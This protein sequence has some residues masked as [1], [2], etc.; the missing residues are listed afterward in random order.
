M[1]S[2]GPLDI[3]LVPIW[4]WGWSLGPGH[5]DPQRAAEALRLAAPT[6]AVPIH[7]GTF[8]PI[9]CAGVHP[10]RFTEPGVEF[11]RAAATVAPQTT[12]RLLGPGQSLVLDGTRPA[13]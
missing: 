13:R 12:V 4:G 5:L 9:G 10:D 11:A 1:G 6:W 3:A 2:L 8:W 7:W